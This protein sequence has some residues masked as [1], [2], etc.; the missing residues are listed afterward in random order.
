MDDISREISFK[1]A[2]EIFLGKNYEDPAMRGRQSV[3]PLR[4]FGFAAIKD[5]R[6]SVTDL[7]KL[8]L[9]DDSDIGEVFLRSFLKWQIPNPDS[10]EYPRDAE[11]DIKPFVG[12]LHLINAVN[13]K[14]SERGNEKKGISRREFNLFVP[15]LLH[16]GDIHTY[17]DRIIALRT[18]LGGKTKE[19]QRDFFERYSEEFAAEFL[20][21]DDSGEIQSLLN[22]LRDYGDNAIRYFRLT[23]YVHIRGGGFY[24]DLEPRRSVEIESLLAHDG[25]QSQSFA[26]KESYLEY[27]SD[28]SEPRLPWETGEK[29]IEIITDLITDVRRWT[30]K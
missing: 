30:R 28:I 3:N 18:G 6:V 16:Y 5:G 14:E 19:E 27:I 13:R 17:A 4:K 12:M 20:E 22:N 2:E 1:E 23:R 29:Y 9:R 10:D 26:S 8:F 25:A 11:Y 24:I 15:T 21:S 7:G